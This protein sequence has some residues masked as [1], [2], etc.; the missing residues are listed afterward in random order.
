VFTKGETPNNGDFPLFVAVEFKARCGPVWDKSNPKVVPI[1]TMT[2]RCQFHCCQRT[3]CPLQLAFAKTIDT[4]QGLNAGPVD[5]GRPP[6]PVLSIIA[7]PG[8]RSFE[9]TKPGLFFTILSRASTIGHLMSGKRLDS[10]IYFFDFGF[11]SAMTR[12]QQ[13]NQFTRLRN[14]RQ[15]IQSHFE[16]RRLGAPPEQ[17]G[18]SC[19]DIV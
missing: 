9:A 14:N 17:A 6:N 5:E 4:F 15:N 11:N 16:K 12:S 7:D 10:A 2:S 19:H 18:S 13:N 3:F 8:N 1:P